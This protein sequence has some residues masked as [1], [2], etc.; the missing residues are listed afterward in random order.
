MLPVEIKPIVL[1]QMAVL[2]EHLPHWSTAVNYRDY[3]EQQ[4]RGEVVCL[5]AW[6]DHFPIGRV[7]LR[8]LGV[9]HG[10]PDIGDLFVRED[11]RSSGV[12]SQLLAAAEQRAKERGYQRTGLGVWRDD[13][14]AR[15]LYARR[16]YRDVQ[17]FDAE[18]PNLSKH[19]QESPWQ[20]V[21]VI[22]MVKLL[23]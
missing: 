22:Y 15:S 16:G 23:S 13:P 8:W 7:L 6:H 1:E 2:E 9:E 19:H 18:R 17:R 5:I 3:L 12:G 14:R 10:C 4:H 11:S 21:D 20:E